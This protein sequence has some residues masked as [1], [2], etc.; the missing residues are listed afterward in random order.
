VSP[1]KRSP[2]ARYTGASG[3]LIM[4]FDDREVSD[5]FSAAVVKAVEHYVAKQAFAP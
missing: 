1:N 2:G 5:R 4:E 3:E